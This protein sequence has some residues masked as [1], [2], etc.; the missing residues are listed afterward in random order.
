MS[1]TLY[2][3]F[4]QARPAEGVA[5]FYASAKAKA[6]ESY[7]NFQMNRV[8]SF[9][10]DQFKKMFEIERKKAD[11]SNSGNLNSAE[12]LNTEITNKRIN[13]HSRVVE[14]LNKSSFKGR[15]AHLL[16]KIQTAF[17]EATKGANS[18][19]SSE[20]VEKTPSEFIEIEMG[21][22]KAEIA[23]K[24]DVSPTVF[25]GDAL[26]G[27]SKGAPSVDVAPKAVEAAPVTAAPKAASQEETAGKEITAAQKKLDTLLA[28]KKAIEERA[29]AM[30][31]PIDRAECLARLDYGR[32]SLNESIRKTIDELDRLSGAREVPANIKEREELVVFMEAAQE[33]LEAQRASEFESIMNLEQLG[34]KTIQ[35]QKAR[36]ASLNDAVL[37]RSA[38][39][40]AEA[41]LRKSEEAYSNAVME[42]RKANGN[43]QLMVLSD[44]NLKV[45]AKNQAKV[46]VIDESDKTPDVKKLV[47]AAEQKPER[48]TKGMLFRLFAAAFVGAVAHGVVLENWGGWGNAGLAAH[49]NA[50]ALFNQVKE[51]TP[52]LIASGKAKVDAI[53]SFNYGAKKAELLAQ[54][55]AFV[56]TVRQSE[57]VRDAVNW[58]KTRW[59]GFLPSP[60]LPD[61]VATDQVAA[62]VAGNVLP[63]VAILQLSK[64]LEMVL[65]E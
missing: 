20:D 14:L 64:L 49:R 46:E 47:V 24:D 25:G 13:V 8:A 61:A 2:V 37:A 18:C 4:A 3:G 27:S 32:P 36:E 9:A 11:A 41:A 45:A 63:H 60:C 53:R 30:V 17:N 12:D 38:L 19:W 23:K 21:K 59:S 35:A 55:S 43:A 34:N 7:E 26:K 56:Q 28:Q 52:G 1:H 29:N 10:A 15:E 22:L 6:K 65:Q 40:E 33:A 50:S 16:S 48:D 5:G 39:R 51:A 57:T 44:P 54:G 62:H 42:E 58:M 31:D